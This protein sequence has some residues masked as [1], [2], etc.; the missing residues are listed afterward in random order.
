MRS[1][2]ETTAACDASDDDDKDD[3]DGERATTSTERV[4]RQSGVA[5]VECVSLVDVDE[6]R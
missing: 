1:N 2:G 4:W 6:R 5:L 3:E